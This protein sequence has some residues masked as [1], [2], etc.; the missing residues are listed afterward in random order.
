[1]GA[2]GPKGESGDADVASTAG[3]ETETMK[4]AKETS[5]PRDAQAAESPTAGGP[6]PTRSTGSEIKAEKTG[7]D[8]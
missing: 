7:N 6:K 1:M 2:Q 4:T 5:L 8:H 3:A